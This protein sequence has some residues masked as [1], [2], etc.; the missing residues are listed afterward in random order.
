MITNI[1]KKAIEI[2]VFSKLSDKEIN[3]TI[4]I[5]DQLTGKTPQMTEEPIN[6]IELCQRINE[7]KGLPDLTEDEN[8]EIQKY[9][10]QLMISNKGSR[11]RMLAK[12][13][14]LTWLNRIGYLLGAISIGIGGFTWWI[15]GFGIGTWWAFGAAKLASQKQS[16]E[17]GPAWEMPAHVIIHVLALC[18]LFGFSIFN[19]IK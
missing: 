17:P 14:W 18:G 9:G 16:Q 19:F 4:I 12:A 10:V 3:P 5:L 7:I 6:T 8:V 15:L 13:L 1:H 11:N 2:W